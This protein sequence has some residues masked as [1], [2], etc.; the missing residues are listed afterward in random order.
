MVKQ[1]VLDFMHLGCLGVLKKMLQ[2]FWLEGN[3]TTKLGQNGK[4]QLSQ[5]LIELQSQIPEEFQ[6]T[7]RS[8][9]DIAKWKA[10][11][12]R[13]FGLY[14]GPIVLKPIL[15]KKHYKHF[16]L[17][18]AAFRILCSDNDVAIKYNGQ[19]KAYLKSF[20]LLTEQ[21]Y[22]AQNLMLRSGNRPL[23]QLCRRIHESS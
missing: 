3:L 4:R 10:T 18:H 13:L 19:A 12:Y 7:T 23:A 20:V 14:I 17:L 2:D 16:L 9:Q 21:Y 22:G 1:F 6:R 5:N 8:V 15:Q 11:E